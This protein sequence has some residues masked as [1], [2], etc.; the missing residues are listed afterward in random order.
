MGFVFLD[1]YDVDACA[2]QC[3]TREA[4]PDG[5]VCK[6][7]NIWRALVDGIP[8]TYTC[9]MVCV[10]SVLR[11]IYQ[12]LTKIFLLVLHRR[13]RKHCRQHWPRKF[14]SHFFTWIQT[15]KLCHRWRIRRLRRLQLFLFHIILHQLE[16][17]QLL[18]RIIRRNHLLLQIIRP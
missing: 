11:S 18:W 16:R 8:T 6:Y 2:E 5:G 4:D 3:N 17:Y 9:S 7:F 12:I 15:K 13:R 1:R 10:I 14:S